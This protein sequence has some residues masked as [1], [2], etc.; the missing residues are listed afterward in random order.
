MKK[1]LKQ[2]NASSLENL[3]RCLNFIDSLNES[4]YMASGL[5]FTISTIGD[6]GKDLCEFTIRDGLKI[7]TINTI[8]SELQKSIDLANLK[9]YQTLPPTVI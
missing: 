3:I 8:K 6:N 4:K 1:R 9:I 2:V 7:E 5:I